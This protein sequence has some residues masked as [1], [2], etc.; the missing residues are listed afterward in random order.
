M[1][2][3]TGGFL[4]R[5]KKHVVCRLQ[6]DKLLRQFKLVEH[7]MENLEQRSKEDEETLRAMG[8]RMSGHV[9]A[10]ANCNMKLLQMSRKLVESLP[11]FVQNMHLVYALASPNLFGGLLGNKPRRTEDPT[12]H[13][14]DQEGGRHRSDSISS[15]VDFGGGSVG[16]QDADEERIPPPPPIEIPEVILD[17]VKQGTT[18]LQSSTGYQTNDM[19]SPSLAP[20]TSPTP[21]P[22]G[23]NTTPASPIRRKSLAH[24]A[25]EAAASKDDTVGTPASTRTRASSG[26]SSHSANTT[27]VKQSYPSVAHESTSFPSSSNTLPKRQTTVNA[28]LKNLSYQNFQAYSEAQSLIHR[29]THMLHLAN[30]TAECANYL[31]NITE[32]AKEAH[33]HKLEKAM[34]Q[35][36][37]TARAARRYKLRASKAEKAAV[38]AYTLKRQAEQRE[39]QV[40]TDAQ[41]IIY[42]IQQ[43]AAAR[44]DAARESL[45]RSTQQEQ[46]PLPNAA[47]HGDLQAAQTGDD[48]HAAAFKDDSHRRLSMPHS[49]PKQQ[50]SDSDKALSALSEL[51]QLRTEIADKASFEQYETLMGASHDKKEEGSPDEIVENNTGLSVGSDESKENTKVGTSSSKGTS[52]AV[53]S[54]H[55][56]ALAIYVGGLKNLNP[57]PFGRGAAH[58]YAKITA[59]K[60]LPS[61]SQQRI[62]E[63]QDI[64]GSTVTDT[65]ECHTQA[66]NGKLQAQFGKPLFMHLKEGPAFPHYVRIDVYAKRTLTK[67]ICIGSTM[68][69]TS[70]L[71]RWPYQPHAVWLLLKE[72][73]KGQLKP[74]EDENVVPVSKN[75]K[76]NQDFAQQDCLSDS[77]SEEGKKR[78]A[79]NFAL[80]SLPPSPLVDQSTLLVQFV[81]MT[82]TSQPT[83]GIP[84]RPRFH[85]A[86]LP[87][88]QQTEQ[89]SRKQSTTSQSPRRASSNVSPSKD[90]TSIPR[91]PSSPTLLQARDVAAEVEAA[92]VEHKG[93]D[94]ISQKSDG[95]Q[96]LE[97]KLKVLAKAHKRLRQNHENTKK[98]LEEAND[99]IRKLRS[100]LVNRNES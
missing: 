65:V 26:G 40:R 36:R 89:S 20:V 77:D 73:N 25:Y 99:E 7:K 57:Q 13:E 45:L 15:V 88:R 10:L 51:S 5:G 43:R 86:I 56:P 46:H 94:T 47:S 27:A 92:S 67:D 83:S 2:I 33:Y 42:M 50:G 54:H 11:R 24:L 72:D 81:W 53:A 18:G 62:S 100:L 84:I 21:G 1:L 37:M 38:R 23:T 95:S 29:G 60:K 48:K 93:W 41:S 14:D 22:T 59:L 34:S 35:L 4:H 49:L 61:S 55:H 68:A 80:P 44:I 82:K 58:A 71:E 74:A 70:P 90:C 30:K 3:C 52:G 79:D 98:E 9:S 8:S 28:A 78:S 85:N 91:R 32:A 19:N 64:L 63:S 69:Q 75:G 76:I 6:K 87:P 16:S 31:S 17:S 97:K 12:S 39:T 96:A 66:H